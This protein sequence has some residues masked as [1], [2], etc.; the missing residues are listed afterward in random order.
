[1]LKAV[2]KTIVF[3]AILFV[4]LYVGM[5]NT[6]E[7]D[8]RFPVAGI[9]EKKPLHATAG[10]IYFGIFAVGLL[11]GTVLAVGGGKGARRGGGKDK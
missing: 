11:A 5:N 2:V 6:H 7:I 3:L 1:M 4:M 9:T 10:L 8:F